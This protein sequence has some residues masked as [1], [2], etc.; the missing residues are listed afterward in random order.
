[1]YSPQVEPPLNR[2]ALGAHQRPSTTRHRQTAEASLALP[3]S[4]PCKGQADPHDDI[5]GIICQPESHDGLHE[6]APRRAYG[7][8]KLEGDDVQTRAGDRSSIQGRPPYDGTA[9]AHVVAD[10]VIE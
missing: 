6:Q 2:P 10:P 3:L 9:H 5:G 4:Q 7:D 1:M 8:T